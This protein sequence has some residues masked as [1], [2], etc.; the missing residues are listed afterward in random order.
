M[1]KLRT[2]AGT[3]VQLPLKEGVIRN[4]YEGSTSAIQPTQQGGDGTEPTGT[5]RNHNGHHME[6]VGYSYS[7]SAE[8]GWHVGISE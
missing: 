8:E 3:R 1:Q 5:G 2:V 6:R 7:G 4:I